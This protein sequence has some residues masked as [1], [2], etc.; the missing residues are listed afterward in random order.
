MIHGIQVQSDL[1]KKAA[2]RTAQAESL[3]KVSG[4]K[5][6]NH[7]QKQKSLYAAVPSV[8]HHMRDYKAYHHQIIHIQNQIA[9]P[10]LSKIESQS[11]NYHKN[12]TDTKQ[13]RTVD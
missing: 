12:G 9:K 2:N 5:H 8:H 4:R 1:Y 11:I 10:F 13:R 7:R 6:H 3:L